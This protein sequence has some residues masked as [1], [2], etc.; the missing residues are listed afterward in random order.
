MTAPS[1]G[2]PE[3]PVMIRVENLGK[4]YKMYRRPVHRLHE[5]LTLGL[6]QRHS[7]FR[8]VGGVT[9]EV[10]AGECVGIMG[11]NGSGKSTLLKMLAGALYPTEGRYEVQGRT[12]SLIE[13]GTGLQPLLT[14]RQNVYN[15]STLLGFP[16]GYAHEKMAEIEEFAEL[17]EFF[18][19]PVRQYSTGMRVRVAF[20]MFACFRP[21]VFIID[22]ALG[23][24][25]VFFQQK[26]A[27]RLR[28][29]LESGMTMLFVSHDANAVLTL[30]SRVIV[31]EKGLPV[32]H[33]A[34]QE[35]VTRYLSSLRG[36][37]GRSKWSPAARPGAAA[38]GAAAQVQAAIIAHDVIRERAAHRHG[39]GGLGIVAARVTDRAGRDTLSAMVGDVLR[40]SILLEARESIAAPRAGLRLFDRFD[41]RVFDA[42][43]RQL[44]HVLPA[45]APGDRVVVHFD[46]PLEIAAG[47]YTFGLGASEPVPDE[48]EGHVPH[49][50]IDLLG[51]IHVA[52]PQGEERTFYGMVNLP[53]KVSHQVMNSP[54]GGTTGSP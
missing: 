8:A 10:R 49:D 21:E 23:V 26:C 44:G 48:P 35:G 22:E 43:T 45:M 1:T 52:L 2:E 50:R 28:E 13:L 54:G 53:M 51:P 9:F 20:S 3:G 17:G 24:G 41:N 34:P 46:L 47:E 16:P 25:D 36:V 33:G 39:A 6:V 19:R 40:F 30:C 31:L 38:S 37:S 32:F 12:L 5:W 18:D 42:G 27:G 4:V 11:A 14:G 15:M 29:L 7:E